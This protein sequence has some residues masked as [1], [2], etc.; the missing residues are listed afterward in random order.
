MF[1]VINIIHQNL[2][3]FADSNHLKKN[4]ALCAT[5]VCDGFETKLQVATV[6]F[7]VIEIKLLDGSTHIYI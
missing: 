7:V 6:I 2:R 1:D 3:L 5:F 4:Q